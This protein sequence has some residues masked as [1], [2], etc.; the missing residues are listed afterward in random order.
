MGASA[1]APSEFGSA[2]IEGLGASRDFIA[3]S[4]FVCFWEVR[5]LLELDDLDAQFASVLLDGVLGV[6]GTVKVDAL[7]VLARASVVTSDDEVSGTV[8]LTDDGV[9]DSLTGATHSHGEGQKAQDGHSVGVSREQGL[10]HSDTGEVID[11][12]GLGQSDDGM[13]Q[14]VGLAG[15]S[16]ADG[17]LTVSSVHG[18][19]AQ[20]RAVSRHHIQELLPRLE[21][22]NSGPAELVEVGAQFRRGDWAKLAWLRRQSFLGHLHRRPT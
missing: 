19:S 20:V 17:Q 13:D 21:G 7:G 8:V 22:D 3:G 18:V 2:D 16:S 11:I 9:P 14:D 12:T 5:E 15:T 4:I 10:V 6:I 1:K